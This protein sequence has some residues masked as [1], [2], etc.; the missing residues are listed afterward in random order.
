MKFGVVSVEEP[1]ESNLRTHLNGPY[2][3]FIYLDELLGNS[4]LTLQEYAELEV[5]NTNGT[6]LKPLQNETNESGD[7]YFFTFDDESGNQFIKYFMEKN[8]RRFALF[9]GPHIEC[10]EILATIKEIGATLEPL[11]LDPVTDTALIARYGSRGFVPSAPRNWQAAFEDGCGSGSKSTWADPKNPDNWISIITG[12][13]SNWWGGDSG[14][15]GHVDLEAIS[16]GWDQLNEVFPGQFL[17]SRSVVTDD[18]PVREILS[19]L[20]LHNDPDGVPYWFSSLTVSISS[21]ANPLTTSQWGDVLL[22]F[23]DQQQNPQ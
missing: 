20:V 8:G 9:G 13:G 23:G 1:I 12:V 17:L 6:V 19:L 14:S 10:G 15:S 2:G 3:L 16:D 5:E 21:L 11:P 4:G 7:A 18:E 22:K